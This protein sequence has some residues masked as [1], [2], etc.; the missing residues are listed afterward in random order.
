MSIL[1]TTDVRTYI[2]KCCPFFFHWLFIFQNTIGW[3]ATCVL[4]ISLE[5]TRWDMSRSQYTRRMRRRDNE[6]KQN[7]VCLPYLYSSVTAHVL[8]YSRESVLMQIIHALENTSMP[9]NNEKNV[10]Q[11][12]FEN[13]HLLRYE[14]NR[15]V[16][17]S[18]RTLRACWNEIC[19]RNSEKRVIENGEA[20]SL[21]YSR[22]WELCR[23]YCNEIALRLK[24]CAQRGEKDDA[25]PVTYRVRFGR[26]ASTILPDQKAPVDVQLIV[27][28]GH[29]F[30]CISLTAR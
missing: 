8:R 28:S 27:Q 2:K 24:K 1:F 7:R 17:F 18:Y 3:G 4:V 25:R 13:V 20:K 6:E 11:R 22:G 26:L 30:Q 21:M 9:G 29:V 15:R 23:M 5:I 14:L 19:G 16:W 10:L 12:S